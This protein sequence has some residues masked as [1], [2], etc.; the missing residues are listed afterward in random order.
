MT[1]GKK[2]PSLVIRHP[3]LPVLIIVTGAPSTG[4]TTL[5]RRIAH[6]FRLPLVAKD[7]I[8]ESLFDTLGWKDREWSKQLGRATMH[9]LFYFVEAQLA[10]GRSCVVESNFRA[11][12]AMQEFRALQTKHNFV[13]L[14]V[15]LKCERDMLVQRFHARWDS[16][17]RHPGHVDHLS[18]AEELA[19][20]LNSDY[21]AIDLDGQVIEI[22]TTD[23]DKIDHAGL[24]RAIASAIRG[25]RSE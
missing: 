20:I 15:V 3:S 2:I 1:E 14:Q 22:D 6:E 25:T 11:R 8:K 23:L 7:D 13:P 19:A 21:Q 4:K 16:G 9:L 17:M 18:S 10:A 12:M 5:A 24:F